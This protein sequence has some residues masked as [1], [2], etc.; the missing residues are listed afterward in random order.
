MWWSGRKVR[1]L[2]HVKGLDVIS[3]GD[4]C[5]ERLN[6][7]GTIKNGI[8]FGILRRGCAVAA[9]RICHVVRWSSFRCGKICDSRVVPTAWLV[10]SLVER[11]SQHQDEFTHGKDIEECNS[12]QFVVYWL[13]N[14]PLIHTEYTST[15]SPAS[16]RAFPS[17]LS[18]SFHHALRLS[19]WIYEE[20]FAAS[21]CA[22][23]AA[24]FSSLSSPCLPF[25][26]PISLYSAFHLRTS[27]PCALTS[28]LAK[29]SS[30]SPLRSAAMRLSSLSE[31]RTTRDATAM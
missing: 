7:T 25:C 22:W 16:L 17:F 30:L 18:L 9:R 5:T 12:A 1:T 29:R 19:V 28:H 3:I 27:S 13:S 8:S 20:G 4:D 10:S 6:T 14:P 31:R 11:L 21:A 26:M 2:A 24:A 23:R 15:S